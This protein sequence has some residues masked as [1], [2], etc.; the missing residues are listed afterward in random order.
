MTHYKSNL[1]DLEFNLFEVFNTGQTMGQRP[2]RGHRSRHG[3]RDPAEV[4]RIAETELAA[5][6][7]ES[8]RNPPVFDPATNT[9][10]LPDSFKTA[11]NTMMDAEYWRLDIAPEL[12]G[13]NAPRTLWWA[14]ADSSWARTRPSGCTP[15]APALPRP[16]KRR[17]PRSSRSGPNCS[18]KN[19]GAR[20]WC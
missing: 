2:V 16:S 18:S 3:A 6:F 7:A 19:S 10:T 9:V 12:G 13:T 4:A 1:R 17:A 20:P 11:Y 15:Q 8:D 5:P 14:F